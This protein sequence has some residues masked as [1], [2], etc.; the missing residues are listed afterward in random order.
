MEFL[1]DVLCIVVYSVVLKDLI[2]PTTTG[3]DV[4]ALSVSKHAPLI[5]HITQIHCVTVAWQPLQ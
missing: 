1:E 5:R 4:V 3:R 2:F